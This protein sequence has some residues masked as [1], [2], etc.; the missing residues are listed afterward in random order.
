MRTQ[1][2][3][4]VERVRNGTS[5]HEPSPIG[6]WRRTRAHRVW[7]ERRPVTQVTSDLVRLMLEQLN[8]IGGNER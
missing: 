8:V 2:Y 7:R 6:Y 1:S 4:A 5:V 3:R